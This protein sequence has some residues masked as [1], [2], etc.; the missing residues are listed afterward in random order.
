MLTFLFLTCTY[1]FSNACTCASFGGPF[2][3]ILQESNHVILGEIIGKP[4]EH[5]VVVKIIEN[6]NQEIAKDTIK[7][8]GQDGFNCGESLDQ[9]QVGDTIIYGLFKW[10]MYD[11]NNNELYNYY[12]DGC[13]VHFLRYREDKVE[14][15]ID[16]DAMSKSY[17]IFKNKIEDC[18]DLSLGSSELNTSLKII[19]YPNPTEEV[20]YVK[21]N[22]ANI[23]EIKIYSISGNKVL[24][25]EFSTISELKLDVFG[26]DSGLYMVE[27]RTSKGSEISKMY[28]L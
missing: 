2:C 18:L 25:K 15:F 13:N 17:E 9:F 22:N 3:R 1:K 26:L 7:V 16:Y 14:G 12:L 28:R 23:N 21:S 4:H 6:I 10:D 24:H 20:L 27:I 8:L 19:T 5:D 11:I